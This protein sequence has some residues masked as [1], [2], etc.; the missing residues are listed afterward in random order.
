[1]AGYVASNRSKN[2]SQSS[3][4]LLDHDLLVERSPNVGMLSLDQGDTY[5][6]V[7]G[8]QALFKALV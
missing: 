7:N 4:W 6:T 5:I 8:A 3:S 2:G 1:M